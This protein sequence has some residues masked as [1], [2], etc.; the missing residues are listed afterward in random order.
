MLNY[1]TTHSRN[2]NKFD[3][4]KLLIIPANMNTL[5]GMTISMVMLAKGFKALNISDRVNIF[6]R[7]GT[8]MAGIFMQEHLLDCV[9]FIPTEKNDFFYEAIRRTEQYPLDYPLLLD[10][11]VARNR[12]YKILRV[13]LKLRFS[14]RPI[15][16]FCHDLAL[17]YNWVGSIIRRLA[18]FLLSP[19][20]I[21]NSHFTAKYIKNLMPKICGILYQPVDL[22]S[23]NERLESESKVPQNLQPILDS[24]A[25]LIL[26]PSRLN[27]PGIVNDKNLRA[28]PPLVAALKARG[29]HYHSVVIGD[30]DSQDN[31]HTQQLLEQARALGI[32]DRFTILP[33]TLEIENYYKCAD[34][35][36][37]MAPREPFGRTVVEAIAC[38]VPVVGSSS[39]GI[40][41]ILQNFAPNWLVDPTDSTAAAEKIIEVHADRAKTQLLITEGQRWVEANC[42][43][44]QY[45]RGMMELVSLVEDNELDFIKS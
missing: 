18:F 25:K 23:I 29:F 1:R 28:L 21:C 5:G 22:A 26:T 45:A 44:T 24:G 37:T 30:D 19:K 41:E 17:S 11:S 8:L 27:K 34:I 35:V 6:M 33:S 43:A 15:Y 14:K 40:C 36:V 20:A 38:G 39:G 7:E 12:L 4:R 2:I 9:E 16:H 10:N 3:Q 13:S 31:Q 42:T 32:S